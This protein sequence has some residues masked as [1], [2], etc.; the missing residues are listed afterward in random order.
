MLVENKGVV[1]LTVR[2]D[3]QAQRGNGVACI[4]DVA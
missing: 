1:E 2:I 3:G 4:V